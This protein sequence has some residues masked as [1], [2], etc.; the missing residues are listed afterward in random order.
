MALMRSALAGP[1]LLVTSPIS[2]SVMTKRAAEESQA[3][4]HRRAAG[5]DVAGEARDGRE[6]LVGQE[7]D[8]RAAP[9]GL[10]REGQQALLIAADVEDDENVALA[11]VDQQVAPAILLSCQ[12]KDIGPHEAIC[13][14][15]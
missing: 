11:H 5:N 4:R 10:L 9:V 12:V 3:R 7:D 2:V 1:M 14:A 13:A 15:M 6:P 8:P